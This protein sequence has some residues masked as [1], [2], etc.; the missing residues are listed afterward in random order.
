MKKHAAIGG[1]GGALGGLLLLVLQNGPMVLGMLTVFQERLAPQMDA[2]QKADVQAV[3][4]S[5]AV[6]WIAFGVYRLIKKG[7]DYVQ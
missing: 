6:L 1:L 7:A 2:V 3:V 5:F 4:V